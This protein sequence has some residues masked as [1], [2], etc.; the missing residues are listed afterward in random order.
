MHVAGPARNTG[1]AAPSEADMTWLRTRLLMLRSNDR[2][3]TAAE[4]CLLVSLIAGV[5]IAT[6]ITFGQA[7]L[8]LFQ[9][10]TFP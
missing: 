5:I 6:V 1:P 9:S 3:A 2:G 7:V 8:G 4:Y 10:L